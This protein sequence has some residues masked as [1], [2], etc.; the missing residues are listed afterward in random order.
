MHRLPAAAPAITLP[1]AST[2]SGCT[3]KN[4]RVAEPGLSLVAP[5][6]GVMRMPPVS[7]CHQVSTTGQR[8]LADHAVIPFPGFRVDRLADRAEQPQRGAR[9]LRHGGVAGLHQ[10]ADRGR[11]GVEDVDLVL[12]DDL[13]EPRIGRVVGHALEHQGGG[14]VRQR[15]VDDVAVPGDPADIGGAP[16]DVAVVIVEHVLVGHRGEH[17]IAA[18]GVE[19][20]LGRAGRSRRVEDEQRILGAHRL[21]RTLGRHRLGDLV[22]ATVAARFHAHGS[23]GAAHHHHAFDLHAGLRGAVGG[24]I[25]VGLERHL[26]AAAQAFIGGHDDGG[27]GILRCGRRAN[28]AR[29]RRTPP[30]GSR[31]SARRPASHRSPRGSSAGRW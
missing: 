14:A 2:I 27:L 19:H 18:G 3:P 21:A 24:D 7:V 26:A 29:S 13:P 6:S 4:G 23:A 9:G 10:R 22:V 15:A 1:S 16:V 8:R 12:V 17:E 5:G 11:C 28:P 31:R 25:G 20:A 30:N